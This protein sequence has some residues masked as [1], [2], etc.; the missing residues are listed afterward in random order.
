V[1][2][3]GVLA[4][5]DDEP[6]QQPARSRRERHHEHQR[7]PDLE[8]DRRLENGTDL[9]DDPSRPGEAPGINGVHWGIRIS[10][11]CPLNTRRV[12]GSRK[13][14]LRVK[15]IRS[16]MRG[17]QAN[18]LLRS[19]VASLP[20]SLVGR[21]SEPMSAPSLVLAND[22]VAITWPAWEN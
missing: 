21:P 3:D 17:G 11:P 15:T 13:S 20:R 5:A 12:V 2:G 4:A 18:G 19:S 1:V 16:R 10:I 6:I 9:L 7:E 22:Y 8:D 14:D